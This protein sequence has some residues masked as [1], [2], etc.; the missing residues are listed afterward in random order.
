MRSL[1]FAMTGTQVLWGVSWAVSRW[2][3]NTEHA[4]DDL[5][6]QVAEIKRRMDQ[7]G[8]KISDLTSDVNG[9]EER[10]RKEFLP[11]T[12]ATLLTDESRR[13]RQRLWE[14]LERRSKP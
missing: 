5:K 4:G 8:R 6:A 2:V 3:G 7:A 12:E 13:D 11:R 14:V 10:V 9:L 1:V